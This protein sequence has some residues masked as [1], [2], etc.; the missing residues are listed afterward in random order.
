MNAPLREPLADR[1]GTPLA[2]GALLLML[3]TFTV[4]WAIESRHPGFA[5]AGAQEC[6]HAY[7]TARTASDTAIIDARHPATGPQK[8]PNAPSC[9]MLR[10]TGELE[11]KAR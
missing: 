4:L 6:R 8:D 10:L 2:V 3:G 5:S 11:G 9:G 1:L 7:S